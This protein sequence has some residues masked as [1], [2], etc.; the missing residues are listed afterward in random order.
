MTGDLSLEE[1]VQK[2]DGLTEEFK[3]EKKKEIIKKKKE[4]K[5]H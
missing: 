3:K 4:E 5:A 2:K 1:V